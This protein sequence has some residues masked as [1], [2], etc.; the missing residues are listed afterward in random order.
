MS[1]GDKNGRGRERRAKE[2]VRHDPD[3]PIDTPATSA[4]EPP[5]PAVNTPDPPAIAPPGA[6]ADF[7]EVKKRAKPSG[8]SMN[9]N[10]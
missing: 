7:E 3:A 4:G 5:P 1:R 2:P 6:P 9:R 8:K 10:E